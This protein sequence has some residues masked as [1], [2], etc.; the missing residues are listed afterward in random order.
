M[1]VS[2]PVLAV[3]SFVLV[4]CG[5]GTT[6]DG[7]RESA[8]PE[9]SAEEAQSLHDHG[10]PPI[11]CPLRNAGVDPGQLK[12]FEEVAEYIA[13]LE[14]EDRAAWQRPEQVVEALGLK[15][16]ELVADVGAGSGYFTFRFAAALPAGRVVAIDIEP[17]MIRHVHHRAVSS[18]VSNVEAVL[19]SPDDPS[20]P[21]DADLVFICDVLHHVR[22]KRE[23]MEKLVSSMKGGARLA[24]V[25]FKEGE[26]PAGPPASLKISREEMIGLATSAGLQLKGELPE[27]LPYQTFF[28]FEKPL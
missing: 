20:L 6:A 27:L 13:F 8:G 4:I 18:G 15:G 9:T 21:D 11:D 23:W 5:P 10:V 22:G 1:N 14:R 19:A 3:L 24:L 17:E 28:V 7:E 25:E 12:P 26:L 16:N 2:R